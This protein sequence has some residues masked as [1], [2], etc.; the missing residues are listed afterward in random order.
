MVSLL[1]SINP[2]LIVQS[3]K[4]INLMIQED[5]EGQKKICSLS[6]FKEAILFVADTYLLKTFQIKMFLLMPKYTCSL[7]KLFQ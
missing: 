2:H 3:V 1:T 5:T 4:K 7:K 6:I